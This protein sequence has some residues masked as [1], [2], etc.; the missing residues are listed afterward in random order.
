[1]GDLR[2]ALVKRLFEAFNRRDEKE[3]VALCDDRMEFFPVVTAEVIGREAPYVG[4]SGLHDYLNDIAEVWEELQVTAGELECRDDTVLVWGRVYARSRELGIRD[5]PVAWIWEMRGER[6][7]RG[8][9][10]TDA[11]QAAARFAA[12][13]GDPSPC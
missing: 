6:F 9:V 11:E 12:G 10:F 2:T 13:E 8:E 1:M 5:V 4:P 3:I 7:V